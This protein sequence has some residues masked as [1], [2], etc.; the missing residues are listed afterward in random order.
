MMELS[1]RMNLFIKV[2][3]I[4]L[5]N[6]TFAVAQDCKANVLIDTDID[7]AMLYLNDIYYGEGNH[8]NL[9]LEPGTYKIFVTEET[10]KWNAERLS[11]TLIITDCSDVYRKYQLKNNILLDTR[12]QNV[13]VFESDSLIGFTPLLIKNNFENLL[14][15]K[16]NY[17]HREI[18]RYELSAG[19]KPELQFIGEEKSVSFYESFLFKALVG[20]AITLGATTAYYKLEADKKFDEYQKTNDPAALDQT[21][22]YDLISGITFVAMQINF[23]LIL[24]FFLSD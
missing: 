14:L 8:F 4:L 5:F 1:E 21:D 7:K 15:Q 19:Y 16:P 20:T 11:D 2:F 10:K 9:N 23:G 18:S 3:I 12:P 17:S 13:Y 24:Y 22:K 6:S